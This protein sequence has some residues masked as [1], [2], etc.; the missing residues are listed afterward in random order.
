MAGVSRADAGAFVSSLNAAWRH[1]FVEQVDKA[2][3][4]LRALAEVV[5][6]LERPRR[7]PSACLL[8]PFLVRASRVLSKLPESIPD[9]VLPDD[10]RKILD[11][12]MQFQKTP[13]RMRD[14]AIKAFADAE[15]A[16]VQEFMDTIESNPL[17]PEQRL[18]VVTDEDATLVLAGAGSGKTSVITAKAAYLIK[19]GIRQ[20]DEILLMAFGKAAAAEMADRIEERSGAVVDALTF[21]ALGN[22]IIRE[23]ESGSPALAPHASDDKLFGALLRDILFNDVAS[24]PGLGSL[25]LKW[26]SEFYWPYKSEWDFKTKDEYYQYVEAHELRTL[27]GDLVKS[28]EEWEIANWLYLNGIA[29]EYEPS[30]EHDL[31][32]NNRQAYTPDFRLTESG[33]YIEHFGVRRSKRADGSFQLSTAPYVDR[34]EY[35]AGMEWKRKVHEDHDTTLIETFSYERVEGDL[36]EALAEKIAPYAVAEPIPQDQVFDT[37]SELGQIDAFTQTLG[38][39]LRHFKS[40]GGSVEQCR[41][42]AGISK[43]AARGNAFLKIFEPLL[44]AYQRRLGDRI[45]FEDMIVRATE[46]VKS[47]R[48]RSPYRHLLVDEFQ[49][50]SE[51]RAKLLLALKQQHSDARI[52]A[53]GDD[54]QSIYRFTGADIHLMRNF[55]KE[56]GGTFSGQDDVHSTVDLGRTFRSVDKIALPARSFVLQNPSQIEKQVIPFGKTDE[57]S[58]KVAYYGRGGEEQSLQSALDN[59]AGGLNSQRSSV[60]LLGRYR[61]LKPE[62]LSRLGSKYPGLSIRFM[63]VHAS[64][65]LEADHVIILGAATNRMGFPSEIVDDPLLDLVLPEPEKFD[66]AEERRLFYVAMTRARQSVIV[67]ADREKPSVFSRELIEKPEYGAIEL[68][69]AGIAEHRCG[70]CGGRMLAHTSKKGR[71]YYQCEHRY[72]CGEMLRPCSECGKDLPAVTKAD[73]STLVCS[74]GAKFPACP[75]CS[76][77]WL[78]K[79][80]G[81]W[82][83]FLSCVKYPACSGKRSLPSERKKPRS[84]KRT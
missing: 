4:E 78:V 58:I 43:D 47:G 38:I 49:D 6:R 32:E 70:A 29:Y 13:Q 30:Y 23:V 21:H 60:L 40:S 52:F 53:V 17:T 20:P 61:F 31:P 15:L 63:T 71:L 22:R 64:K 18:A 50:I 9:G 39:F 37:L 1:H 46:H 45:D 83:K 81:K 12:V 2:D 42:R 69:E 3:E 74:C 59:I 27:Q 41:V 5:E 56:F 7:Y 33:I 10:Q 36:T 16:E 11:A 68:G 54:W 48:Y 79:R 26:F 65:G 82:G 51:G 57:P 55:G 19:R 14:A 77:G 24:M 35:L 66:H 75:E 28:F 25:L 67:L 84:K 34:D 80:K 62:N 76:D 44:E 73:R 72:L 8:E